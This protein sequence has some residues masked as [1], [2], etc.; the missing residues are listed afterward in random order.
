[1]TSGQS[2]P[3]RAAIDGAVTGTR[4]V[5]GALER[6][7]MASTVQGTTGSRRH[8]NDTH[9]AA[10]QYS[11]RVADCENCGRADDE[12]VVVRRVYVFPATEVAPERVQVVDELERWC[13]SCVS[14]YPCE[15][16]G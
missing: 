8:A 15:P 4:R 3:L 7:A 5:S 16:A 9:A 10:R 6:M 12:L 1:M 13:V 14:Q 2:P 11:P